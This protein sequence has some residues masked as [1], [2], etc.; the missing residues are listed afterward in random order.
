MIHFSNIEEFHLGYQFFMQRPSRAVKSFV[1]TIFGILS[2]AF[3]WSLVVQMDDVVKAN[4]F[5]R[6]AATVSL[7]KPLT[8]GQVQVKNYAH[9]ELV[10]EGELIL[11]VDTSADIL[12]LQNSKTLMTR[13]DKTISVYTTLLATI[14]QGANTASSGDDEAFIHSNRYIFEKQRQ[15]LQIEEMQVKL[16]REKN[17]P[18]MLRVKERIGDM[19]YELDRAK[20]QFDLWKNSQIIET[21]DGIK[22]LLQNKENLERRISDLEQNIRNASIYAPI[23]GRINEY[24]KLNIGDNIVPGEEIIAVVPDTTGLKAELYIEPAFI[25]RVKTGQKAILRFPGLP[26]SKFGKIEAEISL[27]PADYVSGPNS[28]PV[29]IAEAIIT[30]PWLVTREGERFFLRPGIGAEGRI[31][32][33]HDSVLRM[34]LKKLDF[35]DETYNEKALNNTKK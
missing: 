22:N 1:L 4:V 9:N 27:I 17:Q 33:D 13:I 7:I 20:L 5:L 26:P 35:I 3:I 25:A 15:E 12:E 16:E 10:T 31:V 28:V 32:I 34:I 14:Q 18:E 11:Q 21:N 24:R 23:S 19:V 2:V 8:G 30:E 6:P 29:F